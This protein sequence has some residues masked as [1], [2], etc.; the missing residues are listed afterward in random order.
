MRSVALVVA[1]AMGAVVVA[2]TANQIVEGKEISWTWAYLAFGFALLVALLTPAEAELVG[3]NSRGRWI[4]RRVYL[5]QLRASVADMETIGVVT[6]GAFVLRMRQVY[7]DVALLP[8][9]A[10]ETAGDSGVGARPQEAV[11]E[12]DRRSLASFLRRGRVFAVL[13]SPGSGK[14]TLV[15]HTAL[16]LSGRNWRIWQREF[17]HR[18]RLPVLLYLRGHTRAILAEQP[19]DLAEVAVS[20]AWL[21]GKIPATWLMRWLERGRCVVLLDGLD[22]VADEHDRKRVL[23]W[24][25]DQI[26]R[27]PHNTFVVTSRPHGYLS[28]PVPNV[29]VLQVQ[30]FTATQ[31][32]R[33]LH[34][35]YRAIERRTRQ[36]RDHDVHAIAEQKADDLIGQ[37]RRQPALYD[38]AANP[39]LLTMIANVHRYRSALPGSR[40]AL[41][42]EMCEV[43]LHRRQEA[44]NLTDP[45]TLTGPQ[46]AAVIRE[47][48]VHMMRGQQRDIEA[49]QAYRVVEQPLAEVC[50]QEK[51]TAEIFLKEVSKSGLLVER[52]HGFYAFAHLTLQEYLAAAQIR[53]SPQL[54]HYLLTGNVDDPWWR[55]TSLLW[56]ADADATPLIEACLQSGTVHA[57]T[58]AFACNDQ[59]RQ[60]QSLTRARLNQILTPGQET[61]AE[62]QRLIDA[63]TASR[64]LHDTI[65]FEDGTVVCT[66]LVTVDLWNR[67]AHHEQLGGRHTPIREPA[68]SPAT[69]VWATDAVRFV[70]WLNGLFDDG[71][72]YRL[73]TPTEAAHPDL[74]ALPAVSTHAIWTQDDQLHLHQPDCVPWPYDPTPSQ[75]A[76]YPDLILDHTHIFLRLF[77]NNTS[78]PSLARLLTYARIFSARPL[79]SLTFDL[80]IAL[81]FAT[82]VAIALNLALTLD[83]EGEGESKPDSNLAL[84]HACAI[85]VD[86][87][88]DLIRNLNLGRTRVRDLAFYESRDLDRTRYLDR[89]SANARDP[90][91]IRDLTLIRD[92]GFIHDLASDLARDLARDLISDPDFARDRARDLALVCTLDL[93]LARDLTL[94]LDLARDLTLD[95][96]RARSLDPLI[97]DLILV[98]DRACARDPGLD[99]VRDFT[100]VSD[101]TLKRAQDPKLAHDRSLVLNRALALARELDSGLVHALTRDLA[102]LR[103]LDFARVLGIDLGSRYLEA[104][105]VMMLACQGLLHSWVSPAVGR[106]KERV[107]CSFEEFLTV[108]LAKLSDRLSAEDPVSALHQGLELLRTEGAD[109]DIVSL[110]EHV[111]SLI[112]PILDRS[113]QVYRRDFVLASA[114]LLAAI[115]QLQRSNGGFSASSCHLAKVL[116]ALIALTEPNSRQFSN[117]ALLLIRS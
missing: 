56:A 76:Q 111:Q 7:V 115:T 40:A 89:T 110:V 24:V 12:S 109:S 17:W 43:L 16:A 23:A 104:L 59:A 44:K 42:A 92:L 113:I 18:R 95:L 21:R 94:D 2:V 64:T 114:A 31:V 29:D 51:I 87:A 91:Q 55:E 46:K 13:G 34:A 81:D 6:Q 60:I 15:R 84:L 54:L 117:E 96:D 19:Q 52:E 112:N 11:E 41:Y 22:E 53:E 85:A 83:R 38:L 14:T 30:R 99:L 108:A 66:Q 116:N 1:G 82:T 36:G 33:F 97:R 72:T 3:V 48:A 39:L 20:A 27:Y 106:R 45:T 10:R 5:R 68:T 26:D 71:T 58:L 63:V 65:R 70:A 9:P 100:L 67:F 78:G 4:R 90:N 32:S 62:H 47:L 25:R 75:L 73:P 28:N 35:W 103:D 49:A 77:I 101:C 8:C 57:L 102:F 50:G 69:G 74:Q 79:T 105:P 86:R 98:R 107:E 88:L 93:D 80:I 61:T 37:L